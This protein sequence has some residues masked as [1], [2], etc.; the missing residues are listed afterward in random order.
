MQFRRNV[1]LIAVI[2]PFGVGFKD[3]IQIDALLQKPFIVLVP[4]KI[5]GVGRM[6]VFEHPIAV[7]RALFRPPTRAGKVQF[8]HQAAVVTGV[9]QAARHER[10]VVREIGVAVAVDVNRARIQAGQKT[11]PARGADRTLRIGAGK[12]HA[13]SAQA[14]EMG[15]VNR[16][17]AQRADGV[18]ALLIGCNPENI[19][20]LHDMFLL[21]VMRHHRFPATVTEVVVDSDIHGLTL[22]ELVSLKNRQSALRLG[23]T[24]RNEC[25]R[26]P[27]QNWRF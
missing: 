26:V 5:R 11:R 6:T 18:V 23:Q 9:R 24:T 19:G 3:V 8:A 20:R 13:V 17:V 14:V 4:L 12:R 21:L 22:F 1:G 15:R 2:H 25:P 7:I 16:R 10:R 27:A